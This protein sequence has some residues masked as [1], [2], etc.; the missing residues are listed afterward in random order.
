MVE[1]K[2]K[3]S[4]KDIEELIKQSTSF[5]ELKSNIFDNKINIESSKK[6]FKFNNLLQLIKKIQHRELSIDS[7]IFDYGFRAKIEEL[8]QTDVDVDMLKNDLEYVNYKLSSRSG[9]KKSSKNNSYTK[10]ELLEWKDRLERDI[11]RISESDLGKEDMNAYFS[12][13][14]MD[15]LDENEEEKYK[16][17]EKKRDSFSEEDIKELEDASLEGFDSAYSFLHKDTLKV[18]KNPDAE[19]DDKKHALESEDEAL[20]EV[21]E[22]YDEMNRIIRKLKKEKGEYKNDPEYIEAR[23]KWLDA[24]NARLNSRENKKQE[25]IL[26]DLGLDIKLENIADEIEYELKEDILKLKKKSKKEI[27]KCLKKLKIEFSEDEREQIILNIENILD[28]TINEEALREFSKLKYHKKVIT[29]GLGVAGVGATVGILT[30]MSGASIISKTLSSVSGT[31]LGASS[32]FMKGYVKK[33]INPQLEKVKKK[34]KKK[35]I[36]IREEKAKEILNSDLI[37]TLSIQE[38]RRNALI[39]IGKGDEGVEEYL[40]N[41]K[42]FLN[43]FKSTENLNTGEKE[44]LAKAIAVLKD[45]SQ[46]NE[47]KVVEE[48]KRKNLLLRG[49]GFG[50]LFGAIADAGRYLNNQAGGALISGAVGGFMMGGALDAYLEKR[51]NNKNEKKI[52]EEIEGIIKN[53][54]EKEEKKPEDL[55]KLKAVLQSKKLEKYPHILEKARHILSTE[56]LKSVSQKTDQMF[57]GEISLDENDIKVKEKEIK[58]RFDNKYKKRIRKAGAYIVGIGTG[59]LTGFL[60]REAMALVKEHQSGGSSSEI[61]SQAEKTGPGVK[62]AED[63]LS[64]FKTASKIASQAEE[65][66]PGVKL[67][68]NELSK[69]YNREYNHSHPDADAYQSDDNFRSFSYEGEDNSHDI[70]AF[71]DIKGNID[72]YSEAAYGAVK[73]AP[74]GVQDNFI[75]RYLDQKVQINDE[76]RLTLIQE[77]VRKLSVANLKMG[78]GNDVQNLVYKGNVGVLKNDGEFEIM[79]GSAFREAQTVSHAQ[80]Q[81]TADRIHRHFDDVNRALS[82]GNNSD[83]SHY[84]NSSEDNPKLNTPSEEYVQARVLERAHNLGLKPEVYGAVKNMSVQDLINAKVDAL[85]IDPKISEAILEARNHDSNYISSEDGFQEILNRP[86]NGPFLTDIKGIQH[87]KES[88]GNISDTDK[89]KTVEEILRERV[90]G[91]SRKENINSGTS[92]AQAEYDDHDLNTTNNNRINQDLNKHIEK[93]LSLNESADRDLIK[94]MLVIFNRKNDNLYLQRDNFYNY[95]LSSDKSIKN[96][97][98]NLITIIEEKINHRIGDDKKHLIGEII[99]GIKNKTGKDNDLKKQLLEYVRVVQTGKFDVGSGP[100]ISNLNSSGPTS[101]VL[102]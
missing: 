9:K 54:N 4:E 33:I 15:A 94:D 14:E 87:L 41:V 92:S 77:T 52:I 86:D 85:H 13:E 96:I 12:E 71:Q 3:N 93:V 50:A 17:K 6:I 89:N 68:E 16:K 5:E 74:T 39:K 53:I 79:K 18:T 44:N 35:F 22:L 100:T 43:N 67:A 72:T 11:Q 88:L 2:I 8:L 102:K 20:K 21:N 73:K 1:E 31:I 91:E 60:A 82:G 58:N 78:D 47:E 40:K 23:Q 84:G 37:K 24:R 70:A 61:A 26:E 95:I 66:G 25:D 80:L 34:N 69:F 81:A 19:D 28:E 83:D 30:K 27:E 49:A 55:V 48:I 51:L 90:V 75:H 42:E 76:N 99:E 98:D 62:L 10:K 97:S 36:K 57:G 56:L 32:G 64:K 38:I 63:E 7:A 45:V 65:N 46:K 29:A 59:V 101:T